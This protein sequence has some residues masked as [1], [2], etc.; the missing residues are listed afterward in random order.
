MT[1]ANL[2]ARRVAPGVDIWNLFDGT[3]DIGCL[4]RFPGE[5][6]MAT[7]AYCGLRETVAA[8]TIHA[9]LIAARTAY[10]G[11]V[12]HAQADEDHI[13]DEDG[14]IAFMRMMERRNEP[15]E[16]FYEPYI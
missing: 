9:T 15:R 10:L 11:C 4:T 16:D 7:V 6:P 3:D 12:E 13:E 2:I 1:S 8:P 5:G 14:E